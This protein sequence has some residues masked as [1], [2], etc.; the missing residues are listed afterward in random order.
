[1]SVSFGV[2]M[3]K[4]VEVLETFTRQSK[5]RIEYVTEKTRRRSFTI[6]SKGTKAR[7]RQSRESAR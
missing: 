4:I 3:D 5:H 6:D 2:P 1:M 7:M